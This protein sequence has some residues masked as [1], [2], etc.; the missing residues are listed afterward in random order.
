MRYLYWWVRPRRETATS[1][2]SVWHSQKESHPVFKIKTN[3]LRLLSK[4]DDGSSYAYGGGGLGLLVV[5][6]ILVLILR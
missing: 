6:V 3:F 1:E 2:F 4:G 5:I